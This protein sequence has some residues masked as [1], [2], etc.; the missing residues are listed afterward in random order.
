MKFIDDLHRVSDTTVLIIEHRLED[1]LAQPIDRILLFSGG[2]IIADAT[3]EEILRTEILSDIGIREP[4]YITAMRYAGVD[5]DNVRELAN[6]KKVNGPQLKEQMESWLNYLPQFR[7]ADY[8]EV[9]LELDGLSFKYP[10]NDEDIVDG[11]FLRIY[12]GE[13]LSLVG[14]NG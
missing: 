11:A 12:K 4:L 1:V 9:L 14:A 10:W 8:D 7:Y 5:L 6:V 13:M 3:P 2:R